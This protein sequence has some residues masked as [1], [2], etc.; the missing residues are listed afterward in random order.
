MAERSTAAVDVAD[1]GGEEPLTAEAGKA[2]ADGAGT[3]QKVGKGTEAAAADDTGAAAE[4]NPLELHSGHKLARRYRLEECVTRLDGFSSWRAVDEKLRRAVGV[5][6]VPADHPR[7]RS[8]LAA[9]R[10]AALLGDPRFVQVLDAVEEN[11]LVYVVHEW[12]PDATELTAV[13]AAGPLEPHDAYQLVSQ[14]SQAMAAAHREGLAHLRLNPGSVLRTESGQYRIRGLAVMAAL[15]GISVDHPQRTDTEAIGA[16]L[17]AALTQRW[18]YEADAYGLSGL[19]KGVGLIAPDQ[20]RAGVHRGLS[21]LAMRALVNDGATASRQDQ[22]CT[23][24]E[25]LAKAVA[26][27][28]RIRPPEPAFT[29]SPAYQRTTYQQGVYGQQ[30]NRG[31]TAHAARPAA[32]MPPPPPLQSRTGKALKWTVSAL[33]IA[34]L[35]LGSW[36]L[37][38]TLLKE[39]N[40]SSPG[41]STGE[42]DDG[43]GLKPVAKPLS[44][45]SATEFSP[46]DAP[47]APD[48]VDG[49]VDGDTNTAW[50]TKLFYGYPNFGNLPNR[51][52][53]SG[54]IVDLGSAKRVSSLDIDFYAAGQKVEVLAADP[55]AS[56]PTSLSA[57]SKRLTDLKSV[58]KKLSTVLDKPVRTRYVL[59]HITELPA[60]TP[61]RYRGGIS[62]IKVKG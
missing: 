47:F 46:L 22:P 25:E 21:E 8:V 35:G 55:S 45:E 43:K 54:I 28:P 24:P 37:A 40:K 61:D 59:V 41:K 4:A 5:H 58:G 51:K 33:L 53:G 42:K 62:E 34:A 13:L 29:P 19:P 6:V 44:I 52:Q 18:P 56:D 14:V 1:S 31:G 48:K 2:T 15:R 11:D 9:A 20:V 23:T 60:S 3:K 39:E 7:A 50:V 49:A 32:P 36:Q 27:M 30:P 57:F 10:S 12:L 38:D 26:A 16:L 17:Y